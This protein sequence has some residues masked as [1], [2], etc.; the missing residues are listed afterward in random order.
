MTVIKKGYRGGFRQKAIA[1]IACLLLL[2]SICMPGLASDNDPAG[3]WNEYSAADV[4]M[5]NIVE[6][7]GRLSGSIKIL[8]ARVPGQ[9]MR[10]DCKIPQEFT[11]DQKNI[12]TVEYAA[13]D[14]AAFLAALEKADG[15]AKQGKAAVTNRD[16]H[17][18]FAEYADSSIPARITPSY[19][20]DVLASGTP[21][22]STGKQ[23]EMLLAARLSLSFLKE[24]GFIPYEEGMSVKRL[25]DPKTYGLHPNTSN[26][27]DRQAE[28]ISQFEKNAAKYGYTDFDYTAITLTTMLRGLPVASDFSWPDGNAREPDAR[29][30]SASIA[31]LL[32]KDG[33]AIVKA[34]LQN[35]PKEVAS[36]PLP[37]PAA[38]WR[39][40]L[41]EWMATYYVDTTT[42]VDMDYK[43]ADTGYG[44]DFTE[45]ASYSVLKEIKPVYISL[46]KR[47][48][49]PAWCFVVEER[50]VKDNA[51]V[52][53]RTF[54]L[55]A[56][57]LANP[58]YISYP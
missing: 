13:Y 31:H 14:K 42:P 49:T 50:L 46:E 44:S 20:G 26:F 7:D 21:E 43:G 51:P 36:T 47:A 10:V 17:W 53:V 30:G 9:T 35:L 45:Y 25:F 38:S 57:T 23:E 24:L 15:L 4:D 52:L 33:G 37:A 48:Y 32:V 19:T 28:L 55:D 29:V 27:M 16:W 41:K 40:A 34:D 1:L 56:V 5:G 39:D 11:Q 3:I 6:K 18:R 58:S 8:R 22:Q 2:T 12:L 54:E